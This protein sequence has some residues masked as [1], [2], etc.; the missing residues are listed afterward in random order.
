MTNKNTKILTEHQLTLII[1]ACMVGIEILGL[2][3]SSIKTA[4]QD[5]WISVM[6]GAIYPLFIG[7][8]TI[9]IRKK[10]PK[11]D[12]LDLNKKIYGDILGNLFN[13]IF[14][15]FFFIIATDLA[16]SIKDV[17]RVYMIDFLSPLN[18]LSLLFLFVAYT[19]YGGVEVIGRVNEI[20]F[21]SSLIVFIIPF[22]SL[23][24]ADIT[25]LQPI[26]GSGIKNILK[27][28]KETIISYSGLEILLIFYAFT[29]PNTKIRKP[30]LRGIAF[31]TVIYTSY[32]ILSILYLGISASQ[33][34]FTPVITLSGSII[35]PVI[36]SFKYVF[37]AL[38]TM[39]IFKCIS[40]Y[41]YI[42]TYGL[43]KIFKK[44]NRENWIIISYPLM[45]IISYLYGSE[46]IRKN[47]IGKIFNY[48]IPYN[49]V[50]I[51][52]TTILIA[53]GKGDKN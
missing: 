24:N 20:L 28:V 49:I 30:I 14:I 53:L 40:I 44:V 3:N 42:F 19:A 50:F 1:I 5:A 31:T 22:F 16:S 23:N 4:K 41:Y 32:T 7:F 34:F 48:Y 10:H 9:Y 21:Y 47:I 37:L 8:I 6:L 25:N 15:L 26:L 38:W 45:V 12:I 27:G 46:T 2:P 39:I 29:D 11:E 51:I 35:I 33:K 18:I 36:N 17:L 43:S 13:L 52:I